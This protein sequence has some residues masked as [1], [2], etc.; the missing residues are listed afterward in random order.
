MRKSEHMTRREMHF[1][2]VRLTPADARIVKEG[3]RAASMSYQRWIE[4]LIKREGSNEK[5]E[6]AR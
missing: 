5:T 1:F 2:A 4:C 3:A 6:T